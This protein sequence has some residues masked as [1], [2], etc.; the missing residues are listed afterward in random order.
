MHQG[1]F[2][3]AGGVLRAVLGDDVFAEKLKDSDD[4]VILRK[5][6]V[7]ESVADDQFNLREEKTSD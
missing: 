4:V 6:C 5:F 3:T 1:D 2:F 7:L